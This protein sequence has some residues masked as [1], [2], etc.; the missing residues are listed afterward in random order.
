[1]KA[2]GRGVLDS[3]LLGFKGPRVER[4]AWQAAVRGMKGLDGLQGSNQVDGDLTDPAVAERYRQL[5]KG[6]GYS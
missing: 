3:Y 1:M 5:S 4:T 6:R 2:P